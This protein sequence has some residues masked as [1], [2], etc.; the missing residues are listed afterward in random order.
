MDAAKIE[1]LKELIDGYL[2]SNNVFGQIRQ[3]IATYSQD[4]GAASNVD[5]MMDIVQERGIINK[6]LRTLQQDKVPPVVR[7]TTTQVPKG[8]SRYLHVKVLGGRA[9]LDHLDTDSTFAASRHE[10]YICVL[11]GTQRLQ[12]RKVP[13]V[14]DPP[15][16]DDFL[17]DLD[18]E[19]GHLAMATLPLQGANRDLLR[20]NLPIQFV[21]IKRDKE[22]GTKQYVGENA[23]EWRKVLRTGVLSISVE[24][25]AGATGLKVPLGV[26]ELQI[27]LIPAPTNRTSVPEEDI[28]AQINSE[29]TNKTAAERE[30]L[31]YARRWW[32]EYHAV[33]KDHAN[34]IVK[35]FAQLTSATQVM[36]PVTSWVMPM[37]A[38]RIIDSPQQAARFVALL[39]CDDD[40]GTT[41][42][43]THGG[44]AGSDSWLSTF[45]FVL[46]GT[47]PICNH[48]ILLC[49]LLLGFGL[50]AYVVIGREDSGPH[51]WVMTRTDKEVIFWES[52]TGSRHVHLK[53][54]QPVTYKYT[55]VGCV[56]NDSTFYANVQTTD[57]VQHCVFDLDDEAKWKPMSTMKMKL[58]KKQPAMALHASTI[59]VVAL[60]EALEASLINLIQEHRDS[61]GLTC[62]WNT[63]FG[64]LLAQALCSYEHQKC[65]GVVI[66]NRYFESAV[67]A[68]VRDGY[69]F[70]GYPMQFAHS[71]ERRMFSAFMQSRTC[72]DIVEAVGQVATH[73]VRVKCFVYAE[74]VVSVW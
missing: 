63:D 7:N 47:G 1:E 54:G 35:V 68:H 33:S 44:T 32:E 13:C 57:Q 56:F 11:F 29:R 37:T 70:K 2:R 73:C 31:V 64:Y 53:D 74:N 67:K 5:Q 12:S 26:L 61:L 43:V 38:N 66:D 59:D 3:L 72:K 19:K 45:S 18:A 21:V 49:N 65:F 40:A 71:N 14:C 39:G 36:L 8:N 25:G 42:A 27:E 34:R 10:V 55:H 30:F 6:V 4:P 17:L 52:L 46:K 48:S 24:L 41:S 62:A 20:L 51:M 15:W 50:E 60:E 58:I 23:V 22:K 9:F 69:T 28:V 16:D